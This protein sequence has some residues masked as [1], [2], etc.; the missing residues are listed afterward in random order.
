MATTTDIHLDAVRMEM[1]LAAKVG[2]DPNRTVAGSF[3]ASPAPGSGMVR[4]RWENFA[5]ITLDQF[6]AALAE[7]HRA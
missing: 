1:A 6:N 4:V 7:A 2:A 3:V 5:D